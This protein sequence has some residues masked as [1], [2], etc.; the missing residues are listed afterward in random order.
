M[1]LPSEKLREL[2]DEQVRTRS[3]RPSEA[4]ERF[5]PG[6]LGQCEP[7]H[8]HEAAGDERRAGV[9]AQ[10]PSLGD[11]AGDGEHVLDRT[12]DLRADDIVAQIDA[13]RRRAQP[14]AQALG[15]RV[16]FAGKSDRGREPIRNLVREGRARKDRDRRGRAD[17][18]RDLVE[19]FAAAF[20]DSLR[21]QDERHV[22]ARHARQHR[23]HMLG[24]SH[25]DPGIATAELGKAGRRLDRGIELAALEIDRVLVGVVDRRDDRVL[26]RPQQGV[27]PAIRRDLGQ[28]RA[29][30]APADHP[31]FMLSPPL[32]EPSPPLRRAASAPAPARHS[33]RSA[34]PRAAQRRPRRSSPH[35]R[36]TARRA[37]R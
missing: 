29:P 19:H 34:R 16:V 1:P 28:R 25:D 21:A 35:C 8:F 30:G 32:R 26:H 27:A 36:C 17:L 11:A 9:L 14:L 33:H 15:Q 2:V 12:A 23:A 22:G 37:E 3:P 13:E 4:G 10:S 31:I 24:R 5:A 18:V 6:A 7:R 20:L